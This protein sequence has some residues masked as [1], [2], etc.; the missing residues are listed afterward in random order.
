[1]ARREWR[2][3][4]NME[5][6]RL[7]EIKGNKSSLGQ[8]LLILVVYEGTEG[9][10]KIIIRPLQK[11]LLETKKI[12]IRPLP[13]SDLVVRKERRFERN[14]EQQTLQK[15]KGKRLSLGQILLKLGSAC[16]K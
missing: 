10:G 15:P 11:V 3:E 14:I 16:R 5:Q 9:K 2:F 7:Q 1:M 6:Q 4:R 13:A 8:I 12:F